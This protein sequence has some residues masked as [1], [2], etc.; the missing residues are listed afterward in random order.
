METGFTN[1]M[2]NEQ[3]RILDLNDEKILISTFIGK[4]RSL[5]IHKWH[6]K[7]FNHFNLPINYIYVPFESGYPYGTAIGH[8][9]NSLLK[10]VDYH[11]ILYCLIGLLF[12]RSLYHRHFV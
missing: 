10:Y 4:N 5:E 7:V 1:Q 3:I 6:Q 11:H 12:G 2:N 8:Y 9:V